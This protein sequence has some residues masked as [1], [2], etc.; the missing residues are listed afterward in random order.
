MAL[1]Q[2]A[3]QTAPGLIDGIQPIIDLIQPVFLKMS[4]VV[5]GIFGAYIILILVRIHYER[6][7]IKILKAI[8]YDLDHLNMYYGIKSSKQKR[9]IGGKI[10]DAIKKFKLQ[11]KMKREFYSETKEKDKEIISSSEKIASKNKKIKKNK[12]ESKHK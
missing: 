4:V 11:T 1:E 2:V 10:L 7:S 9:G 5:G 3:I 6:K 12:N 8:R